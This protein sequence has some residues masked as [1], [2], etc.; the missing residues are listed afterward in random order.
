MPGLTHRKDA[1]ASLVQDKDIDLV[2]AN[3]SDLTIT[4]IG[5]TE[6][7]GLKHVTDVLVSHAVCRFSRYLKHIIDTSDDPT[8]ITLGGE[9]KRSTSN[10]KGQDE[11]E[12]LEGRLI[13]LA[14][15][16]G[17]GERQM[18]ELA[19]Y[20][21]SLLGVWYAVAYLERDQAGSAA[22]TLQSWFAKWYA[23]NMERVALTIDSARGLVFLCQLFN[24]AP[25][26]T[27]VT[28]WLAYNH[29]GNFKDRAPKGF[30]G[31]HG[32]N[33]PPAKFVGKSLNILSCSILRTSITHQ[34][35][36]GPINHARAGLKN[37]LHK[38]LY[39]Q[40]GHLLRSATDSCTCW[41]ATVGHYLHS[42][43]RIDV[44][45]VDEAV[46]RASI[47][48]LTC[49]L[50]SFAYDF[51]PSCARCKGMGWENVVRKAKSNTEA[52][53]DGLCLDCMERSMLQG[54][55]EDEGYWFTNA[56]VGRRWDS[57]CRVAHGQSTWYVSWLGKPEMREKIMR[58]PNGYEEKE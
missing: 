33:L 28:K 24:H 39:K 16:H 42:L 52:Y 37:T 22:S 53:F 17:L 48:Q 6:T 46:S 44:F 11:G 56:S 23:T 7:D 18:V 36:P 3:K 54:D 1:A 30:N 2:D 27:R 12:N 43:T 8:E 51:T 21:I 32:L 29:I 31:F 14:H 47:T 45:P 26:F 50:D 13:M 15:L 34:L 10:K 38:S 55:R 41:A 19:L 49:R 20:N 9:L 58:G 4:I 40:C 35:P 5:T 57:R 25:G